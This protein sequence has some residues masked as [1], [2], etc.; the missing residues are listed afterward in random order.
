MN[1]V[2]GDL[3]VDSPAF[4][5]KKDVIY[6]FKTNLFALEFIPGSHQYLLTIQTMWWSLGQL[7][8]S[9]VRMRWVFALIRC[10]NTPYAGRMAP[11]FQVFLF[12]CSGLRKVRQYGLEIPSLRAWRVHFLPLG[13]SFLRLYLVRK[14]TVPV[15]DWKRQRGSRRDL[16]AREIQRQDDDSQR[17]RA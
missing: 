12:F 10:T 5:G 13:M 11:D 2:A 6:I 8:R 3:S 17:R 15:R 9:L 16:P 4:L 14:S 1:F 7:I